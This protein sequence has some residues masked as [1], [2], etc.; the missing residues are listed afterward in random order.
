MRSPSFIRWLYLA[1]L[2]CL[3]A[4][5]GAVAAIVLGLV[6]TGSNDELGLAAIVCLLASVFLREA[7]S[8]QRARLRNTDLR[9][10]LR[11][12]EEANRLLELT[13][14]TAR[15]GHWRLDLAT[16]EVYWSPGTFAIHGIK[17]TTPPPL[18]K[19]IEL[20]HEDDRDI[21]ENA[22]EQ[23]R[24]SGLP[25]E[26]R[27]RLIRAD[28]SVRHTQSTALVEYGEDGAPVALFGVF[29]DRTDEEVMQSELRTARNEAN[30]MAEAKSS[31]L[32]KMSH[33]I[34]TPMNG[35]MGFAELLSRSDLSHEQARHVELIRES[36]K[37]LQ[38]LL[39]DILD[40]SKIE[41]GEFRVKEEPANI[42][43]L[44]KRTIQLFEPLA[45]EKVIGLSSQV[46]DTLPQFAMLDALRLRQVLSNLVANAIRFTDRGGVSV[47][48][49]PSPSGIAFTVRDTG[50]GIPEE[51]IEAIFD[52]FSQSDGGN[53]TRRGGTGLGL[54]ISRQLAELMGGELDVIST[55][56]LGS[57]FILT[58][59]LVPA[60]S[61]QIPPRQE[62]LNFDPN[63][64]DAC[65]CRILLAEDFDINQELIREMGKQLGL[66]FDLVEDGR[67]A[68][69]AVI[70]ANARG[71]PY[72][73]VLMDLQM[74]RM[75]GLEATR[76]IRAAGFDAET[77]PI[78]ALT[79]NAFEDDIEACREAGIQ[80]HV[81][82]P[83][84]LQR[85]RDAL[86][87][88]LKGT[89][90]ASGMRRSC[91]ARAING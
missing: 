76:A 27:A 45:R 89:D 30:A 44:V 39:N 71:K 16:N 67:A 19:A 47:I 69:D 64:C 48:V 80:E 35:V 2:A 72:S 18:D 86:Q 21:V 61:A 43:H 79:A 83:L 34:R 32:A 53:S 70:S 73:L 54:S 38:T 10:K 87:R 14:T 55:V 82:K 65:H 41:S 23:S 84:E 88:W 62:P 26:F 12:L 40:L 31:F 29:C 20:F 7:V 5:V 8:R 91:A 33:E 63:P 85:L 52:P 74:P 1:S 37:A 22:V 68:L 3:L 58:L 66:D 75:D 9:T 60:T 57:S 51:M 36:G 25:F 17:G 24:R 56:G 4:C 81:A 46:S 77:L 90:A 59:P 78:I 13:E 11:K 49:E 50:T 42:S 6:Q 15:V 28:G